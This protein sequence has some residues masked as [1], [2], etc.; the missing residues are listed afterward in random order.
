MRTDSG[1]LFLL[2]NPLLF[3]KVYFLSYIH[4]MFVITE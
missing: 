1:L 2:K 3:S 4:A